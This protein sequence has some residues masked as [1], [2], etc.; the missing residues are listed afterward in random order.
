MST[1]RRPMRPYLDGDQIRRCSQEWPRRFSL[2]HFSRPVHYRPNGQK[3][4][5]QVLA[6]AS[7]EGP[8]L[9]PHSHL[10]LR[11]HGHLRDGLLTRPD[12]LRRWPGCRPAG[13]HSTSLTSHRAGDANPR[14]LRHNSRNTP[15]LLVTYNTVAG[16]MTQSLMGKV[17]GA[18]PKHNPGRERGLWQRGGRGWGRRHLRRASHVKYPRAVARR[19]CVITRR[20]LAAFGPTGQP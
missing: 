17:D 11:P 18:L 14:S 8:P 12:Q 19:H 1:R 4:T 5:G 7:R 13:A 2:S 10:R 16:E 20:R 9:N 3:P 15:G 6:V